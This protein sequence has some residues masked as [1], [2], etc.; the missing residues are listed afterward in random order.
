[1][2]SGVISNGQTHDIRHIKAM[3]SSGGYAGRMKTGG[4]AN[5]GS[6]SILGLNLN[7]GQL[8][9]AVQVFVPTIRSGSVQGWQS[10][11]TVN[12]TGTVLVHNCGYAGGYVG[13]GYG[14]QIWGDKGVDNGPSSGPTKR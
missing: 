11:M 7:I 8:V 5:F 9:K 2:V 13:S 10:G 4:A 14:A 1:M 3:R 6:T 12:A